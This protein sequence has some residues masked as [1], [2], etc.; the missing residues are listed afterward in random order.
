MVIGVADGTLDYRFNTMPSDASLT[1]PYWGSAIELAEVLELA[2]AG[3][4]AAHVEHF[5][6]ERVVDAYDRMRDGALT[7][8]AV[9][10]P[11]G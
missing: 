3:H 4:L 10:T 9:I 11:H 5:P 8:R 1:H 2:R 6:L 7:G